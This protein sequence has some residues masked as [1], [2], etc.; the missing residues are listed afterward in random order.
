MID[1]AE[2]PETPTR[3]YDIS[4]QETSV[5]K[6]CLDLSWKMNTMLPLD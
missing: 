5:F 2:Y 3:L 1:V 4:S 6:F